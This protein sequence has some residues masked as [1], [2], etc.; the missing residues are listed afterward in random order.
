MTDPTIPVVFGSHL[1][2]GRIVNYEDTRAARVRITL[3]HYGPPPVAY[4]LYH[5]WPWP[6]VHDANL[7]GTPLVW[8]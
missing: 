2:N 8:F 5:L 4:N 6:E 7:T 3:W 1:L